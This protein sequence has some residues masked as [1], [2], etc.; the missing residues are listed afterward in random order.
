[1]SFLFAFLAAFCFA[2]GTVLM[3]RGTLQ[4]ASAAHD[5][6]FYVQILRR[7]VW[8]LGVVFSGLG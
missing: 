2:L 7:P 1:M 3:Q 4:T 6:R 8:L 5:P